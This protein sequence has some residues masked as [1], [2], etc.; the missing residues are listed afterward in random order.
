MVT[1]GT[2]SPGE[3][4]LFRRLQDDPGTAGWTVLH[5]LDIA[6]HI[7]QAEG[8]ID[9]VVIVPHKGVVCVEVK[10]H[11]S[12]ER[13]DGV[14]FFGAHGRTEYRGPFRQASDG[15]HSIR[16]GLLKRAREKRLSSDVITSLE[17]VVFWSAVL[18]PYLR[19]EIVS[20]EWHPW[21]V[22]D[23]RSFLAKP[24]SRIFES[25]LDK[26]HEHLAC[27]PRATWYTS[28][29]SEPTIG[30]CEIITELLRPSFEF[31]ES[32]NSRA[33]RVEREVKRYT[34]GQFHALSSMQ[35]NPRVAFAGPAGTGKTTLA[36]EAT[37][38]GV[39]AGRRVLLLCYNRLLG[40]ELENE[41]RG[42]GPRVVARTLHAHM[43]SVL[44]AVN[45]KDTPAFWQDELPSLSTD[46][47][48]ERTLEGQEDL[49]FDELIIDEAQDI[50][51]ESFLDFL[52]LSL[53]GGLAA[54][55]WRLF[56]DFE[57]QTIYGAS[58]LSLHEF[59][60]RRGGGAPQ[61]RLRVNCR[62][63][64]R[65]AGI[66]PLL[67]EIDAPYE[68]ILRP[69]EKIDPVYLFYSSPE[70]QVQLLTRTLGQL[71]A[72]G[73]QNEDVVVL[74]PFSPDRSTAAK[75]K[76]YPWNQQLRSIDDLR[77]HGICARYSSIHAFKGLEAPVI[78]LTDIEKLAARDQTKYLFYIG[79]T[80]ALHKLYVLM[81]EG[82]KSDILTLLA[83]DD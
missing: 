71:F 62:N 58:N 76:E 1:T 11:H 44:N 8:E 38:R 34:A 6:N 41:T 81:H 21:Q 56:G 3:I 35:A 49:V 22:I 54:G 48:L 24:I 27:T 17:R 26:A 19:F 33:K 80:R 23:S 32:P 28:G 82:V 15:M 37:R 25:V 72:D 64:P 20:P 52:D 14:W 70:E 53:K 42:L 18:F 36:I 47:L 77:D 79:V 55:Q 29:H 60:S 40:K 68:A 30:Q 75:V 10:A 67:C 78:I 7:R 57:H 69:D 59:L 45:I 9:F 50:L 63:T 5:S 4:E 43:L 61:Y 16:R 73:Y 83:L 65:I 39:T 13:R 12:V 46:A 51:R 2:T 74:S 66:V 31:F